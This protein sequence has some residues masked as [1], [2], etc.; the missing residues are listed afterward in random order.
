MDM[1]SCV[2]NFTVDAAKVPSGASLSIW[3]LADVSMGGLRPMFFIGLMNPGLLGVPDLNPKPP[4]N[5]QVIQ[6]NYIPL[7]ETNQRVYTWKMD[8]LK[9]EGEI[10]GFLAN[11]ELLVSG[12]VTTTFGPQNH[13]RCWF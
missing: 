8:S 10:S 5:H 2:L 1:L 6:I 11:C 9:F 4:K 7:P 13:K 12:S 3:R